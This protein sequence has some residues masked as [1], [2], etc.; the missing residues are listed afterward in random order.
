[1]NNLNRLQKLLKSIDD[2]KTYFNIHAVDVF[3]SFFLLLAFMLS[4]IYIGVKIN[5]IKIRKEWNKNKCKPEYSLLAGWINAPPGS[6]FDA[7]LEYTQQNFAS[8]N[9]GILEKNMK[10]FTSP[11]ENVQG[12]IR[13]LFDTAKQ[14]IEKIKLIHKILQE[15]F[16]TI[17]SQIFGKIYQIAIKLQTILFKVKD[18]FMKAAGVLQAGF[19][20][21][22]AQA[23]IFMT[24]INSL[25]HVCI[26]VLIILTVFIIL[27]FSIGVAMWFIPPLHITLISVGV[28][29]LIAYLAMAIPLLVVIIFCAAINAELKRRE[30][31]VC[32]HPET[33]IELANGK[34]KSIKDLNL[35]EKLK[36]NIEVIAVL[37]IKGEDKDKYYKIY[38]KELNDYIFV[39]GSHLIMHPKTKKFIPVEN[40]KE[41]NITNS[42]TNEMSC[43]VTSTHRIPIGE[44]TFW[45]WED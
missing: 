10:N 27:M 26:I 36:N 2:N 20:I 11:F 5:N 30:D 31:M 25:I 40:F 23:Y 32:F 9:V 35:G 37:R 39:T 42:W 15:K 29:L 41:A 43:L 14:I 18:T 12:I 28:G 1:M 19:L 3:G 21:I 6:S 24:F 4:F 34:Y 8:C 13:V 17:I 33:K 38:S 44:Y 7:K 45:D 22:V 16:L